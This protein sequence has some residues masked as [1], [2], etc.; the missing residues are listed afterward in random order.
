MRDFRDAKAM[1][2]TLRDELKAKAVETT[3]S[4]CL[5]LIAKAFGYENWNILSAKIEAASPQPGGRTAEA[6]VPKTL[7]CSF[8]GKTQHEVKTLIA[9]PPPTFVCDECVELCNEVLEDGKFF[10]LLT[11]DIERGDRSYS[12]ATAHLRDKSTAELAPYMER[13]RKGAERYRLGLQQIARKLAM[14]ADEPIPEGD[15][16]ASPGFAY[17]RDKTREE[18]VALQQKFERG[19]R[20][21]DD[22]QRIA[23]IVLNERRAADAEGSI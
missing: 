10:D 7:S 16:L 9:G 5:E 20:G 23:E 22:G 13:R 2:H 4:E 14:R 18:L 21:H 8:C 3:H 6:P 1:A 19:L 11:A 12:T 17:L 15:I